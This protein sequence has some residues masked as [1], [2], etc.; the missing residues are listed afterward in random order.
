MESRKT[1]PL[2]GGKNSTATDPG[3]GPM[4]MRPGRRAMKA[5]RKMRAADP[6][7]PFNYAARRRR[8]VTKASGAIASRLV[9]GSGT[10]WTKESEV[11]TVIGE[12]E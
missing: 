2:A 11:W 9:V 3:K 5:S 12:D 8:S 10:T 6:Q 7:I 4:A 1:D